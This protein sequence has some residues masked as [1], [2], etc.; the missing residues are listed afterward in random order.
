MFRSN[1]KKWCFDQIWWLSRYLSNGWDC[2]RE[3]KLEEYLPC[4]LVF[5]LSLGYWRLEKRWHFWLCNF[6]HIWKWKLQYTIWC[7][8]WQMGKD[9]EW[10]YYYICHR[11]I[12]FYPILY[13]SNFYTSKGWKEIIFLAIALQLFFET[14]VRQSIVSLVP[15]K[16]RY[17]KIL[18]WS[19]PFWS[20]K[21]SNKSGCD[22]SIPSLYH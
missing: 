22:I 4:N 1:S 19:N 15:F 11:Y 16:I 5:R 8:K 17:L 14:F 9:P 21:L 6:F 7:T 3:K 20:T 13:F 2:Q 18:P 12:F 10:W